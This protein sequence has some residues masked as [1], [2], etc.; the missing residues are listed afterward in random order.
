MSTVMY[1]G[2]IALQVAGALL[3]L[4]FAVSTKREKVVRGFASSNLLTENGNTEE[5]EYNIDA[6]KEYY[7]NAYLSKWAFAY[8]VVG[9]F[10]GVFANIE[11]EKVIVVAFMVIVSAGIL[12]AIAC[13]ITALI[14]KKSSKVNRVI[15]KSELVELGIEADIKSASDEEI[16]SLF[17]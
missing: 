4:V 13:G 8:I 10:F 12:I 14:I 5:I 7:R 17:E 6:F 9:Y 16:C 1:I 15:T 2:A 3:L 11:C